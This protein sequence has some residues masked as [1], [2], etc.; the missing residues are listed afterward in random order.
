MTVHLQSNHTGNIP[1]TRGGEVGSSPDKKNFAARREKQ[2]I[3]KVEAASRHSEQRAAKTSQK[4]RLDT[5]S[6]PGS[7]VH[8]AGPQ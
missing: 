7:R 1:K 2:S 5:K 6:S 8:L 3:Q 4:L